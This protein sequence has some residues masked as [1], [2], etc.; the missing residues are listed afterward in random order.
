MPTPGPARRGPAR[1]PH[2][3]DHRRP[4][5]DGRATRARR[6]APRPTPTRCCG[7]CSAGSAQPHIGSPQAFSFNVPSVT[8]RRARSRSTAAAASTEPRSATFTLVGGMCPRCEGMGNVTDID[9]T[10]L[11]DDDQVARRGR[12]HDPR[13]HRGRLVRAHL[14]AAPASSTR[15]SR[16]REF[17]KQEL[18]RPALQ[19]A[20]QGQDRRHQHDLRG[21]RPEDPEVD[22]VQGPRRDAAA[23]PGVRRARGHVH[24]LP[25]LR[26]HPARPSRRALVEDRTAS[27]SPTPARC[28]SATSPAWVRGLDEPSVAP[29]LAGAAAHCSTRSSR[30][31]WATSRW[32]ARRARCP[33]ARRSAPR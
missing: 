14:H 1:G 11:Y 8:R 19:G 12:A 13:L 26:R 3:G 6:S 23:H 17:T 31:A 21:P 29:L 18:A 9:L 10:Q 7:S 22:A 5:A 20:D 33:A 25:G 4:G 32:T 27:T 30:S 2:H 15:T 24:R 16:S 28:R